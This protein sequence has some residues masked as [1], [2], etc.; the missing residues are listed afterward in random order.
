[1]LKVNMQGNSRLAKQ[2]RFHD[3]AME[4]VGKLEN[5]ERVHLVRMYVSNPNGRTDALGR[6]LENLNAKPEPGTYGRLGALASYLGVSYGR[7][8]CN[9]R[10]AIQDLAVTNDTITDV[11]ERRTEIARDLRVLARAVKNARIGKYTL[12]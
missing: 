8:P 11:N 12:Y 5:Q 1:M 10:N 4:L 2:Y 6:V 3:A 9:L 7:L